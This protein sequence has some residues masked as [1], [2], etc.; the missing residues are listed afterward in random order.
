MKYENLATDMEMFYMGGA[1]VAP[2][3]E[4]DMFYAIKM[5]DCWFRVKVTEMNEAGT[6]A[7][8]F[9]IDHGDEEQVELKELH[10]LEQ[11][12]AKLPAQVY[13][14]LNFMK[15]WKLNCEQTEAAQN[16][17]VRKEW[18]ISLVMMTVTAHNSSNIDSLD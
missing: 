3:P 18:T 11:R 2:C 15:I 4:V 9:F 8:V 7:N 14:R 16:S 1:R 6:E 5:D 13:Y 12:F 10:V 17:K